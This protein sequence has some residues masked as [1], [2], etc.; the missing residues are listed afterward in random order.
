MFQ[1]TDLAGPLAEQQIRLSSSQVY[2]LLTE[3]PKRLRS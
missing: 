1:T 2:R 3:W